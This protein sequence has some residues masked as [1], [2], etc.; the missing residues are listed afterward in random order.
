MRTRALD[1]VGRFSQGVEKPWV[2]PKLIAAGSW[3]G[4]IDLEGCAVFLYVS[5]DPNGLYKK[6][7]EIRCQPGFS[8]VDLTQHPA[9]CFLLQIPATTSLLSRISRRQEK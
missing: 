1:A 4:G 7:F 2:P 5:I 8:S 6:N 3:P 9:D